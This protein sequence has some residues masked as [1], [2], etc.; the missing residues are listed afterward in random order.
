MVQLFIKDNSQAGIGG[1]RESEVSSEELGM[2][3][4]EI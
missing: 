4:G 2:W 3:K 1:G